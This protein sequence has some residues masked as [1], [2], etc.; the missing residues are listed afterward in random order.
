MLKTLNF[1]TI[2]E[3]DEEGYFV[4]SVPSVPG[5]FT[6]GKSYEEAVTNIKEVL[7]LALEVAKDKP[8]YAKKIVY[9]ESTAKETFIGVINLPVTLA[10][11]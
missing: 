3:Q 11:K 5:C 9:P 2:I 1:K 10:L 7:S 8:G 6:Q 4:A